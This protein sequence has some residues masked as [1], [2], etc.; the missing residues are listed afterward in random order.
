MVVLTALYH[1]LSE[2]KLLVSAKQCFARFSKLRETLVND[3][4]LVFVRQSAAAAQFCV[5]YR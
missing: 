1:V 5:Q 2:A 3:Q 4:S